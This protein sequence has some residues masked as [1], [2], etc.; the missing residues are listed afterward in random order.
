MQVPSNLKW[1][2]AQFTRSLDYLRHSAVSRS[3]RSFYSTTLE[4]LIPDLSPLTKD[5][6][7]RMVMV[8]GMVMVTAGTRQQTKRQIQ[9]NLRQRS[10]FSSG[11]DRCF[12]VHSH[13]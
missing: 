1:D 13:E 12:L 8:T 2:I 5:P 6:A 7:L 4:K 3:V 9:P 11:I 10:L